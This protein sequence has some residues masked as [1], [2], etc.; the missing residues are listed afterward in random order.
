MKNKKQ[1]KIIGSVILI[2]VIIVLGILYF[3][4]VSLKGYWDLRQRKIELPQEISIK[5]ITKNELPSPVLNN[6]KPPIEPVSNNNTQ[7]VVP[8]PI[9]ETKTGELPVEINLAV[10]FVSQAPFRVWDAIHEE[11][12]EEASVLMIN[13][14]YK[15]EKYT[16]QQIED[17]LLKMNAWELENFGYFADTNAEET[18]QMMKGVYGLDAVAVYDITIEDIKKELA[19]G[20]PVI[21]PAAGKILPNP[22]FSNGGPIYHMLVLKGYTKDGKF[23]S[24][25]PGTN[26]L[27]ENFTYTFGALYNAIHDWVKDGDILTGRKA[28]I[29][30]K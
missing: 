3:F 6:T 29:V 8:P 21:V 15:S 22:Y 23:I 17:E 30:V 7:V 24:N 1:T 28:M 12:C 4:R 26:T 2:G 13:G 10:P 16:K 27:G 25:D 5:D 14:F 11:T 9:P 18:A 19:A 20:H